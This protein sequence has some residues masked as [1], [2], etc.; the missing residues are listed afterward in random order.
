[1]MRKAQRVMRDLFESYLAEPRQLPTHILHRCDEG[2]TAA[3][4]IADYIAG[5]T[6]RFAVE[7]HAKLFDPPRR[8]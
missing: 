7:E 1:M 8:A 2:E 3:R 5:M 4:V 6:D